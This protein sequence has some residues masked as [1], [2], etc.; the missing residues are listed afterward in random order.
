MKILTI[1][2]QETAQWRVKWYLARVLLAPFPVNVMGRL[3][4]RLMQWAGFAIGHGTVFSQT[5][6]IQG[7]YGDFYNKLVVGEK[8][9]INAGAYFDLGDHIT[10]GK[11]IAVGHEVLF[12]TTSHDPNFPG[13]RGGTSTSAPIYVGD[14]A[15]IASRA[16]I[17]PGVTIGEGAIVAAGAVV[18]KDVAPHTLV[19]GVPAKHLKD[20]NQFESGNVDR[21]DKA[22]LLSTAKEVV[23]SSL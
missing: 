3:R 2:R 16:T 23:N 22:T 14:G 11:N 18:A 20:L 6:E 4:T 1:V 15:W 13:R 7:T 19:G 12:I 10:L 17:L 8:C 5:P 21:N 9:Y